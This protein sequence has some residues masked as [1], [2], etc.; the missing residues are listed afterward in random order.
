VLINNAAASFVDFKVTPDG[1]ETQLATDHVGPFLF[2][3]LL[4]PT[5]LAA[6]TPAF[7]PRVVFVSSEA[8]TFGTGVDFD[9]LT[10]PDPAKYV[11]PNAYF[12]AKSANI[13]TAI[14]LSKRSKGK[15]NAYSLNPGG[16]RTKFIVV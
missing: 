5:L 13:L 6:A 3:K 12:Q 10:N 15:I 9:A 2:T 8:H 11:T 1:L 16:K 7:T 14:E 4:A